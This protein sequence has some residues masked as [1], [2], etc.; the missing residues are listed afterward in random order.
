MQYNNEVVIAAAGSGKTSELVAE[1]KKISDKRILITTFTIENSEEIKKKFFLELGCTPPNVKIQTWFSFLLSEAVRPYQNFLYNKNRIENIEF[2]TGQSTRYIKK[3]N[4]EKYYFR[5]GKYIYTDKMCDFIMAV[6]RLSRGAIITRLECLYDVIMIDE[7]QDL[8]GYDLD[9][10]L[11]LFKS[12]IEIVVVGDNR[13]AVFFTSQA[14]RNKSKKG[15]H[16]FSLFKEWE[17]EGLCRISYKTE[18]YRSNQKICNLA[19]LLY[20]EMPRTVSLNQE[21][22]GHDGLFHITN[23]SI[24]SY[25]LKYNPQVLRYN[26]RTKFEGDS[27]PLN[28]RKSKGLTFD[29]VLILCNG[30]LN[31]FLKSGE[32][33]SLFKSRSPYYVALTR[34]RYSVCFVSHEKKIN[35]EYIENYK[36]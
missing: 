3:S 21:I 35:N 10:L 8:A 12:K 17:E 9:F 16:I 29:R 23:E 22:T 32:L 20:P 5:D 11:E 18:C 31:K 33:D 6:N 1:A 19:D 36:F 26:K 7:V 15:E 25:I 34:A 24:E 14:I 13:Q 4:V 28:F 2:V 30:P 27:L